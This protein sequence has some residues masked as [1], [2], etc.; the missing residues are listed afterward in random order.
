M[1]VRLS[2][3]SAVYELSLDTVLLLLCPQLGV[4][5]AVAAFAGAFAGAFAAYTVIRDCDVTDGRAHGSWYRYYHVHVLI[6]NIAKPHSRT[7]TFIKWFSI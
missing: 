5:D 7:I 4:S 2:I 1:C 3:G 6:S